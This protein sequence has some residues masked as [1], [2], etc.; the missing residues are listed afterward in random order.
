MMITY[1][2]EELSSIVHAFAFPG[3]ITDWTPHGNGH[4][5]DTFLVR[6]TENGVLRKSILQRMNRTVFH[7]PTELMQNIAQVTSFLRKKITAAG[8]D[9]FRETLNLIPTTDDAWFFVDE[10]GEFWRA[11]LFI[12]DASCYDA[13]TDPK[14]FYETGNAFGRFQQMLSDFPSAS[15]FETIPDFHNTPLRYQALL[16]AAQADP[17]GRLKNVSDEMA[18]FLDHADDYGVAER[19]KASGELPLRVT[20]NDTK[21]NNVLMDAETGDGVCV[22]DLDTVMP[23]L[24]AY[25][26]GDAIRYGASTAAED[27]RDL[28]RVELSLPLFETYVRGYLSACGNALTEAEKN[29]LPLGA[30]IMTLE[31]G[32]RFL[33]DYLQG[34]T[35]F[36][37]SRPGQN[38]DRA[39]TQLRLVE[40][41]ER[42]W[43][44]MEEIAA[45]EGELAAHERGTGGT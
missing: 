34:D 25:D 2:Q 23:G 20:H 38:L 19:M 22:I 31:C 4:I 35:Y 21:L 44:R 12:S 11:F 45:R 16:Q 37:T 27:E 18:F 43:A 32:V 6:S 33:T 40:D 36:H 7:N 15:L 5:N 41:M 9:P 39:R 14:L 30:K 28:S 10:R 1:T 13:V 24:C 42:K 8:G 17:K 26:F 3:T 29:L